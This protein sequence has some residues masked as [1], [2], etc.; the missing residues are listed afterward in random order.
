MNLALSVASTMGA[1]AGTPA[2]AAGVGWV[3]LCMQRIIEARESAFYAK[4]FKSRTSSG[5]KPI[6]NE[7]QIPIYSYI[8][9]IN[10]VLQTY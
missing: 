7:Q 9:V 2:G 8:N 5:S 1:G 6:S 3:E 4:G 10:A